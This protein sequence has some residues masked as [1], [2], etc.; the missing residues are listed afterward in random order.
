MS[1]GN[2]SYS[3]HNEPYFQQAIRYLR[4]AASIEGF[5]LSPYLRG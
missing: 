4:T 1:L 2:V 5:E 3:H